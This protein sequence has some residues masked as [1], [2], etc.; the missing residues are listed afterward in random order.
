MTRPP[1][2]LAQHPRSVEAPL[3]SVIIPA[4]KVA[5][6]IHETLDAIFAQ[7]F[8]DYEVVIV[9]DGSPDTAQ[10]EAALE[11]YRSRIVYFRQE[12]QGA[13]E[14]RNVA[15]RAARGELVAFL[16]A[17]DLWLPHYLAEQ[18]AFLR[19]NPSYD[20]VYAD[21]EMFGDPAFEGRRYME[22]A[23][24][25][26]EVTFESLLRAE[27]NLITSGVV[28]RRQIILDVGLFDRAIRR[29]HDFD[30]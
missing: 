28:A 18:V 23:R 16:D 4:Y 25:E 19:D 21:A 24:S 14:A 1:S 27:C 29:G 10:L 22:F 9:N 15:L 20:L 7:T 30:L 3:V 13:A 2:D 12:N 6:Y 8:S 5:A 17:D 26:G 11:P